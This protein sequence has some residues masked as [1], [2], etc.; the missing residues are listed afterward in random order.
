MK[1]EYKLTIKDKHS[2]RKSVQLVTT[3]YYVSDR[4]GYIEKK[5]K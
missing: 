3:L 2:G 4:I 1:D 5:E